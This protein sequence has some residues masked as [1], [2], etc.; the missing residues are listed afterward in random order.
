MGSLSLLSFTKETFGFWISSKLLV[1]KLIEVLPKD[2]R[3]QPIDLEDLTLVS[4]RGRSQG[5]SMGALAP[6]APPKKS[7]NI[8]FIILYNTINAFKNYINK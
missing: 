3:Y 6:L 4:R 1:C 7:I 2:R 5:R 8:S